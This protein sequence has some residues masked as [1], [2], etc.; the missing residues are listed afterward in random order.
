MLEKIVNINSGIMNFLGVKVVGVV[1]V[2]EFEELGFEILWVD[3]S[4][5]NCV[6]YLVVS[7][8]N[9][10]LKILMIGYLD[11]VFVKDDYF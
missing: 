10:G 11:I 3:G 8:G 7:Y 4:E 9:M 5:F 6:G 2:I 1:Y